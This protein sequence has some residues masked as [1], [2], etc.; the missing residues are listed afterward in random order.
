MTTAKKKILEFNRS[1]KRLFSGIFCRQ[2]HANSDSDITIIQTDR[3]VPR[4]INLH[5]HYKITIDQRN[6]NH[7]VYQ[8]LHVQKETKQ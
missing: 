5:I 3:T 6:I 7:H 1:K 2:S 4:E 8:P